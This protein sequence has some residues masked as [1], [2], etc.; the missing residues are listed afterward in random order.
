MVKTDLFLT[1]DWGT[2]EK[3]RNNHDRVTIINN[4]LKALGYRTWFDSDRMIGDIATQMAT[5]IENTQAVLVFLTQ[6]Y[7]EKVIGNNPSDNCK[8]EFNHAVRKKTN[9]RM[10]CIVMEDRMKDT[11][12]WNG[13]IGMFLGG[14][15]YIDMTKD[16]NNKKYLK[17][18]FDLLEK[19]LSGMNIIPDKNNIC[20]PMKKLNVTSNGSNINL[21]GSTWSWRHDGI[22]INGQVTFTKDKKIQWSNGASHG[23]WSIENERIKTYFNSVAHVLELLNGNEAVLVTPSRHP[24]SKMSRKDITLPNEKG[25]VLVTPSKQPPSKTSSP[26]GS[27]INLAGSTWSWRHDGININGQVTFTKDKKIQ[28]NNGASHGSWSIENEL[29]TTNFN[30]VAHV[31]KL[32]NENEA[33]LDTPSRNPPSKMSRKDDDEKRAGAA[34][35]TA[36]DTKFQLEF[37]N[38]HTRA[39]RLFWKDYQGNPKPIASPAQVAPGAK[40]AQNTMG[41]H[42]FI[43]RD[44]E[45]NELLYFTNGAICD[46]IGEGLAFGAKAGSRISLDIVPKPRK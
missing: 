34:K 17:Q 5:G 28:W 14:K 23:S 6:R 35:S 46:V 1:H 25:A 3:G 30:G 21:A 39:I 20:E 18:Q 8:L 36:Y 44:C 19:E 27:N 38:K 29:I 16:I 31:L 2:D 24:P 26:K 10:V 41:T 32:L 11:L 40:C 7:M 22:N 4:A 45:T 12:T 15:I 9:N 13:S 42:P 37:N 43:A 33:V